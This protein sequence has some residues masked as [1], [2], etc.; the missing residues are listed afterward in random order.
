MPWV[1]PIK[2]GR[3]QGDRA[4]PAGL[5]VSNGKQVH[6]DGTISASVFL[7]LGLAGHRTEGLWDLGTSFIFCVASQTT[8]SKRCSTIFTG[9][10]K[11]QLFRSI[12]EKLNHLCDC[13]LL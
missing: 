3:W 11:D 5:A 9:G 2:K 8:T 1:W 10:C 12:F 6:A 7:T 4:F 13:K